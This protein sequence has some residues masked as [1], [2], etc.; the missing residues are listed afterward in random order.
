MPNRPPE[1]QSVTHHPNTYDTLTGYQIFARIDDDL[2]PVSA[3]LNYRLRGGAGNF[4]KL[5]MS[6]S[7][8]SFFSE[9]PA[10]RED[11]VVEYFIEARDSARLLSRMPANAPDSLFSFI[12]TDQTPRIDYWPKRQI[13]NMAADGNRSV[14]LWIGNKGT[15]ELVC[16]MTTSEII[17]LEQHVGFGGRLPPRTPADTLITRLT[18]HLPENKTIP[19]VDGAFGDEEWKDASIIHLVDEEEGKQRFAVTVYFK[20]VEQKVYVCVD[21]YEFTDGNSIIGALIFGND[22][23]VK[24]LWKTVYFGESRN[25]LLPAAVQGIGITTDNPRP[26]L[27]FETEIALDSLLLDKDYFLFAIALRETGPDGKGRTFR[28]RNLDGISGAA[29]I[30]PNSR[31]SLLRNEFSQYTLSPKDITEIDLSFE[32]NQADSNALFNAR[33]II[34]SNDPANS[35]VTMP[36]A[37]DTR[38]SSL[39][40]AFYL[41]PVYPNPFNPTTTIEFQI[42]EETNVSLKIYNVLGQ[43]VREIYSGQLRAGTHHFIWDSRT[44]NRQPAATGVYF[45]VVNTAKQQKVR[46]MLLLR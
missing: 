15:Q 30:F 23:P 31:F 9:I 27:I 2:L 1:I 25:T 37:V 16:I 45:A 38:S 26:H 11:S 28:W 13:I 21:P 43:L 10:Q 18:L 46:K 40:D 35:V 39:P 34:Y 44:K 8:K 14:K 42:P 41:A 20:S 29:R 24:T 7:H 36:F 4:N 6:N 17:E 32:T 33:V 19:I 3:I 22:E 5:S 12:I